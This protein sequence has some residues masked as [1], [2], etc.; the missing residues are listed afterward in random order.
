MHLWEKCCTAF[1][2]LLITQTSIAPR[3]SVSLD[4]F[5]LGSLFLPIS[6]LTI[7]HFPLSWFD[8]TFPDKQNKNTMGIKSFLNSIPPGIFLYLV[9]VYDI[10]WWIHNDINEVLSGAIDT[11]SNWWCC[12][13]E[14]I[15]LP[16]AT[17][18]MEHA[19]HW[20]KLYRFIALFF[21]QFVLSASRLRS[22]M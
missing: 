21:F 7:L 16:E 3:L 22:R 13:G 20:G 10:C 9:C 19:H 6:C 11:W 2:A 5:T 1:S 4:S 8:C 17:A 18:I 14:V 15:E 12:V